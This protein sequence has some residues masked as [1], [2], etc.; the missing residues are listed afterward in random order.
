[1][2]NKIIDFLKG[3]AI[4]MSNLIPGYSGGT[5][6]VLLN[7]YDRFVMMFSDIFTKP[8]E[9]LKDCWA[10]LVGMVIGVIVG[11]IG[12][13]KLIAL[14]PVQTAFFIVGLV[15]A[16]Y[17]AMLI[18][19][20]KSGNFHIR[21][22][23]AFVI[24]LAFIVILPFLNQG[25]DKNEFAWFVPFMMAFLGALCAAAMVIPGVSGALILMAFGYFVFV[26][27]KISDLFN[28]IIHFNFDGFLIP[29][30][31]V[32]SFGIGVIIGLVFISKFIKLSL[33]NWPK[34]VY[35]A[36]FGILV[37]SPFAIFWAIY[38]EDDYLEKIANTHTLGYI[39]GVVM[40]F[41]GAFLV[42]G[43]PLLLKKKNQDNIETT[44]QDEE[45]TPDR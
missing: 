18:T 37:A 25:I 32:L 16:G 12:V 28:C 8:K 29:F 31:V 33:K 24:S 21:D 6:A 44:I 23:I 36:I 14:F 17:P 3:I 39:M 30:I 5:T 20:H 15:V 45:I 13:V 40:F 41:V 11:I 1:M 2:K 9:T 38:H 27:N 43:L 26:L 42:A 34:T 35:M 10:L 4:G 19:I 22:I 7:V